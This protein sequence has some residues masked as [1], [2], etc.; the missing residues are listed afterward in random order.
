MTLKFSSWKPFWLFCLNMELH[1]LNQFIFSRK[2]CLKTTLMK[3]HP[4]VSTESF[5]NTHIDIHIQ[6]IFAINQLQY[7][8]V[9]QSTNSYVA[10]SSKSGNKKDKA[11]TVETCNNSRSFL[12]RKI[13]YCDYKIKRQK[14]LL[15]AFFII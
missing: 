12:F 11:I 5:K 7:I 8:L 1:G 6:F 4:E 3:W 14:W 13:W 10:Y 15:H 2:R 9:S